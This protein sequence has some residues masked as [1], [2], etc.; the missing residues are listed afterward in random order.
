MGLGADIFAKITDLCYLQLNLQKLVRV[1]ER[2]VQELQLALTNKGQFELFYAMHMDSPPKEEVKDKI[3]I[4]KV[5]TLK[6]KENKVD[7]KLTNDSDD[8]GSENIS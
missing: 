5:V 7:R 6:E 8:T 3:P 4:A 2:I 1:E